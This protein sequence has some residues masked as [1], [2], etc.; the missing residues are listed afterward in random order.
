MVLVGP[1]GEV[2]AG[3]VHAGVDHLGQEVDR[4]RGRAC[5]GEEEKRGETS[6]ELCRV[7]SSTWPVGTVRTYGADD[8]GEPDR[9]GLAVDVQ[10][11]EVVDGGRGAMRRLLGGG[12]LLVRDKDG[13]KQTQSV[14]ESKAM[15]KATK[16]LQ[17]PGW[18][19]LVF[20]GQTW[21]K[22]KAS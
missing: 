2:H 11:R 10:L 7:A 4:L 12:D 8:P 19:R 22:T 20:S 18:K 16:S 1:V 15:S 3:H 21:Q 6:V 9:S 14:G 17:V 13:L 5:G